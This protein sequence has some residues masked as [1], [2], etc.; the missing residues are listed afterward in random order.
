MDRSREEEIR[1]RATKIRGN[2]GKAERNV[3]AARNPVGNG[4]G[5]AQADDPDNEMN[6]SGGRSK[7]K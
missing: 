5:D 1:G 3:D 6:S 4:Q 2:A 7:S